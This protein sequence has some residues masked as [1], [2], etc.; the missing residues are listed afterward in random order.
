MAFESFEPNPPRGAGAGLVLGSA[1]VSGSVV[2]SAVTLWSA[3][4]LTGVGMRF[5]VGW[6]GWGGVSMVWE[7]ELLLFC[8]IFDWKSV[9]LCAENG[10]L[11]VWCVTRW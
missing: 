3:A 11:A 8:V 4:V 9:L 6:G 5:G 2:S 7:V 1:S 10:D